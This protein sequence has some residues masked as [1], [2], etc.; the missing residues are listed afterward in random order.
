MA[1]CGEGAQA[2]RSTGI[3]VT[4]GFE[5]CPRDHSSNIL[6]KTIQS[7]VAQFPYLKKNTNSS[8]L[9]GLL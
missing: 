7:F 6:S 9:S 4:A 1:W 8:Y 3:D 5:S 2:G